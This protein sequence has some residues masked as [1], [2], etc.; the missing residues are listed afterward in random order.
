M[1][2]DRGAGVD[3]LPPRDRWVANSVPELPVTGGLM[4]VPGGTGTRSGRCGSGRA[5]SLGPPRISR[6]TPLCLS[7][8]ICQDATGCGELGALGWALRV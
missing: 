4:G 1:G 7:L 6:E 8:P 3:S 2:E 5:W